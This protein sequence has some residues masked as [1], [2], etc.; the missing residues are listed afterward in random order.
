VNPN[1]LAAHLETEIDASIRVVVIQ[2]LAD[3]GVER[4]A[5]RSLAHLSRL[6]AL[7][8]DDPDSGI[9]SSIAYLLRRWGHDSQ[10]KAVDDEL[11]RMPIGPRGWY[12]NSQGHTMAI[13]GG[14]DDLA[15]RLPLHRRFPYRFAIATTETTLGQ[16]LRFNSDH[17]S[18]RTDLK[19]KPLTQAD[20]PADMVSYND[21]AAYCNWLSQKEG[22]PQSE[23][24]YLLDTASGRMGLVTDY[25]VRKGYR[26]PNLRE[27]EYAAR[28]GTTTDR[29]FGDSLAHVPQYTWHRRNTTDHAEVVGLKRPN[30]FGL[31][32]VLGNLIEWCYNPEP[33]HDR[34]CDCGALQGMDCSKKEF[35]ALRGG[36]F[37][38]SDSGLVATPSNRIY[39]LRRSDEEDTSTG[40]RIVKSE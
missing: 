21:A 36:S 3:L 27:W 22:L 6:L 24:C 11:G 1:V 5:A 33:P 32:D 15:A 9:H 10:L 35:A 31:F 17:Q 4:P 26:L 8:R 39:D 19:W 30:D 40:F 16:Y 2:C 14:D 18:V 25:L 20:A 38:L 12:V 29:Y 28:A 7:Y 13:I 34:E 23:W 37:Q